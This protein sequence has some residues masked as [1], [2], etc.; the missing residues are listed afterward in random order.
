MLFVYP[1]AFENCQILLEGLRKHFLYVC[2]HGKNAIQHYKIRKLFTN[3]Q[4]PM[5]HCIK[6]IIKKGVKNL[7]N[8]LLNWKIVTTFVTAVK[9]TAVT[10]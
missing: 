10:K 2:F 3:K 8:Y 5:G 7:V 1:F 9:F 6:K 4:H